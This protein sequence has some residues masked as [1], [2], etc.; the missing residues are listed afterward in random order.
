MMPRFTSGWPSRAVFDATRSVQASA[1]SQPPPS[2]KPFTAG[3]TG[4]PRVSIVSR[5]ACPFRAKARAETGVN[6][7][8]IVTSA[9][10]MN[11]FSPAP[12]R[13]TPPTASSPRALSKAAASPSITSGLSALSLSGRLMVTVRMRS[14]TSRSEQDPAAAGFAAPRPLEGG[15]KPLHHLRVERVELVGPVDGDRE[16]AIRDLAENDGHRRHF[17]QANGFSSALGP[18][19]PGTGTS[20]RRR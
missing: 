3:I 1:T 19:M 5:S 20:R 14:E 2:A 4:L 16:D 18:Y 13:I 15:G 8:K 12:V 6:V 11:A 17:F 9:P 7:R 10:A